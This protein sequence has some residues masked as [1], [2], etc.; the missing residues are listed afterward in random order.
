[1]ACKNASAAAYPRGRGDH[2]PALARASR[3]CGLPPRARG[4]RV[5]A[6]MRRLLARPTPAGAGITLMFTP[7]LVAVGAYPRGRGDHRGVSTARG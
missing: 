7:I 5:V 1:L 3:A 6:N 2:R 4:S